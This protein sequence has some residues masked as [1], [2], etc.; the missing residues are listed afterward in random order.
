M[1][2]QTTVVATQ[3]RTGAEI[4]ATV[5]TDY[6]ELVSRGTGPHTILPRKPGGVLRFQI[7]GRTVFAARVQHP[8]ARPNTWWTDS[9]RNLP[10]LIRRIWG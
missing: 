7:G 9:L 1:R 4:V 6:A 2:R 3:T 10:S 8:G 5:D